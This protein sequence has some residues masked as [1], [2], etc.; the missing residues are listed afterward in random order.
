MA[1][2]HPLFIK[3][4]NLLKKHTTVAHRKRLLL[5]SA[6]ALK[7]R[8]NSNPN[9]PF[10]G[11]LFPCPLAQFLCKYEAGQVDPK[12]SHYQVTRREASKELKLTASTQSLQG[13]PKNSASTVYESSK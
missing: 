12:L 5:S 13:G 7:T 2:G 3:S 6:I 10:K 4:N 11:N 8:S 1:N 9:L